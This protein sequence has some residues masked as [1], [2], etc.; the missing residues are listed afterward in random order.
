MRVFVARMIALVTE[1]NHIKFVDLSSP[2]A[3]VAAI[4]ADGPTLLL[5]PSPGSTF[6][7]V[8]LL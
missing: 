3:V 7:E 5:S 4:G 6:E 1:A 2:D 8:P